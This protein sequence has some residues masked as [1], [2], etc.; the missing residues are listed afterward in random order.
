[1]GYQELWVRRVR[2]RSGLKIDLKIENV[3]LKPFFFFRDMA[4]YPT[5]S[6]SFEK[7]RQFIKMT[8]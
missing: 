7:I 2:R 3:N 4:V 8:S 1:M 5:Q 6:R